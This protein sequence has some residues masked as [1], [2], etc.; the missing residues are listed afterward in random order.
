[1]LSPATDSIL[2]TLPKTARRT[3]AQ[4]KHATQDAV[5]NRAP[6]LPF[7]RARPV[8]VHNGMNSILGRVP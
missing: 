3:R 4:P 6:V 8:D 1:M 2:P 5:H 7:M